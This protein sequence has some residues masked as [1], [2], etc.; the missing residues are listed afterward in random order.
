MFWIQNFAKE[1]VHGGKLSIKIHK[2]FGGGVKSFM[3]STSKLVK[4]LSQIK[5]IHKAFGGG[6][7]SFMESTSKLVKVLSQI[8]INS[9]TFSLYIFEVEFEIAKLVHLL[10][11]SSLTVFITL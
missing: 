1:I 4:V 5:I 2:A 7:N 9:Q 10:Q 8:K 11:I 3:E 6:V